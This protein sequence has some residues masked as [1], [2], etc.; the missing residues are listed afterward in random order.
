[1][2]SE[3]VP[4]VPTQSLSDAVPG[5]RPDTSVAANQIAPSCTAHPVSFSRLGQSIYAVVPPCHNSPD[6]S[7]AAGNAGAKQAMAA[8]RGGH[9][10]NYA[11]HEWRCGYEGSSECALLEILIII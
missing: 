2:Q 5:D 9:P 1:M 10:G 11:T 3:A 4:E 8:M 7:I 6:S